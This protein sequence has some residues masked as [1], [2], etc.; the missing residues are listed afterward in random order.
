MC[1]DLDS[2]LEKYR[3]TVTVY[4]AKV[5]TLKDHTIG[6]PQLEYMLLWHAAEYARNKSIE[7]HRMLQKHVAEHGCSSRS[8]AAASRP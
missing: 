2:L 4:A 3:S 8:A 1:C 5:R 7:A 6:I